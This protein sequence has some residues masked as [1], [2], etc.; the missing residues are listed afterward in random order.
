L[1]AEFE[2]NADPVAPIRIYRRREEFPRSEFAIQSSLG[3]RVDQAAVLQAMQVAENRILPG[4]DLYVQ[5]AWEAIGDI[6]ADYRL[7]FDLVNTLD[8]QTWTLASGLQP[9]Q[10]G[11]PTYL[12]RPGDRIVDI[13]LLSVPESTPA[14]FY[15]LRLVLTDDRALVPLS[16]RAS[17]QVDA[18]SAGPIQVGA[19]LEAARNPT[20][21]LRVAFADHVVLTGYDSQCS[22]PNIHLSVTLYWENRD[23][24]STDYTVFVQVLTP[25]H[26]VMAQSDSPPLVPTSQWVPGVQLVDMHTLSFGSTGEAS[27]YRVVAGLYH[28]PDLERVP[29][30]DSNDLETADDAVLLGFLYPDS[31]SEGDSPNCLGL[32]PIE[33]H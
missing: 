18:A 9:M 29:V 24:V 8:G 2:N 3:I 27:E 1:E 21:P 11:N 30:I 28:W 10:G 17:S 33:R 23:E 22:R 16:D 7:H 12:W 14:D 20:I 19:E 25:E 13:H 5:L 6:R 31:L 4:K 15:R 32:E 26:Q